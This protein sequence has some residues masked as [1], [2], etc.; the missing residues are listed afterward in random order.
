VAGGT[1]GAVQMANTPQAKAQAIAAADCITAQKNLNKT[2]PY[3]LPQWFRALST[4][5]KIAAMQP[6][7]W[8]ILR[9]Q[10]LYTQ[11]KNQTGIYAFSSR[12]G[13]IP[14]YTDTMP[15]AVADRQYYLDFSQIIA[16]ASKP[17]NQVYDTAGIG[18]LKSGDMRA[19]ATNSNTYP[20]IPPSDWGDKFSS[21][22][23]KAIEVAIIA[24]AAVGIGYGA[25][26]AATGAAAGAAGSGAGVA[27]ASELTLSPYAATAASSGYVAPGAAAAIPG[28]TSS[29]ASALQTSAA[30]AAKAKDVFGIA[31]LIRTMTSKP[32]SVAEDGGGS[33][34]G[35]G[36]GGSGGTP[37][38]F[39][40]NTMLVLGG[41]L[42]AL[43]A[44][45]AMMK[46]KS[47]K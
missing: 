32:A 34:Q 23:S 45:G 42:L 39:S 13:L 10:S 31:N 46:K 40:G 15:N 16:N 14:D 22:M 7:Y 6:G 43:L 35:G 8:N 26:A 20:P 9:L 18:V 17:C 37:E 30:L 28:A 33:A 27:P 1:Y 29:V 19:W 38:L 25:Y 47:R 24:G 3:P 11:R 21:A 4:A 12:K 36:A 2:D 41:G 44:I 5:N